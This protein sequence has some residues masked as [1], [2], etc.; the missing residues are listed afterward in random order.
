VIAGPWLADASTLTAS[1]AGI[2]GSITAVV[3][4]S[5][6]V[7]AGNRQRRREYDAEIRA[8]EQRG[9]ASRDEEVARIRSDCEE[10]VAR[11]RDDLKE[12]RIETV[13]W[14]NIA[15]GRGRNGSP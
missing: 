12:S 7:G 8:A 9:A 15:L 13:N 6:S 11:L 1:W 2:I 4:L 14:R 3:A 5:L 10:R